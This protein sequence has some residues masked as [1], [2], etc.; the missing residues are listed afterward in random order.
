MIK[1]HPDLI[2][3]GA[4]LTGLTIAE[5]VAGE[6]GKNVLIYETRS[7]IG[8][9]A[10]S[11]FEPNSGIEIHKYGTHVFHTA[12]EK[13]FE[14]ISGFTKLNNFQHEVLSNHKGKLYNFP[15]N[16]NTLNSFFKLSMNENEAKT[17]LDSLK[18]FPEGRAENLEDKAKQ[19]VG[20]D[21]YE[22]FIKGYSQKQWQEDPR[23]LPS[24]II[25]RIPVRFNSDSRYFDAPHQGLPLNG[26]GA[27][28][29]SMAANKK[30]TILLETDF[31]E[32][33]QDINPDIPIVYTGPI[34]RYFDYKHGLLGWRTLDFEH[35]VLPVDSFQS[36]AVVNYPD[37]D[38]AFT[39]IHEFK[40]LY[41]ER[42]T[43]EGTTHIMREYSRSAGREDDPFYPMNRSTD[44]EILLKYKNEKVGNTIFA[45]RLGSYKYMDMD[46]AIA[47]ALT[48]Y[49]NT[50]IPL[51]T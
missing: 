17:F 14:Y 8:G 15:I 37:L 32:I 40:K 50:I 3:V 11:Y 28:F 4:G 10:F 7:H 42:K 26:Y 29:E 27:W 48:L 34:D 9:N 49:R 46:V 39:R 21:L 16:L 23:N 31:F 2:V 30:I 22:S 13:V 51:L 35:E 18:E 19:L 38:V 24:S 43:A 20:S 47:A 41:P 6:L 33:K 44:K 36:S 12:N 45:G 5:R 1:A 25:N